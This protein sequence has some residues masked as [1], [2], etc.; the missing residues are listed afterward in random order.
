MT[1]TERWSPNNCVIKDFQSSV[2]TSPEEDKFLY[3]KY[4]VP[5]PNTFR[6]SKNV[7]EPNL[8]KY[9][10]N[11]RMHELLYI[12]EMAQFEQISQFNIKTSLTLIDKYMLTTSSSNSSSAKYARPGE[13]FGKMTL[14]GSLSKDT[15]SGRLILTHCTSLLLKAGNRN[16]GDSRKKDAAYLSTTEGDL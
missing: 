5:Q 12:E 11:Q 6:P 15:M 16:E 8:T 4:P 7:I 2:Q 14:K 1:H 10:Y 13:L 9:N 3:Q